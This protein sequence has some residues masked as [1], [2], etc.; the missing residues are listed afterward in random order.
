MEHK[1]GVVQKE[2]EHDES[3]DELNVVADV[4]KTAEFEPCPD[5]DKD[6]WRE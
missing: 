4:V 1:Y 6:F 3:E 5:G 2:I